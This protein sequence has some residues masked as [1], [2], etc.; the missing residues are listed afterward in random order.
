MSSTPT[1]THVPRFFTMHDV[2]AILIGLGILLAMVGGL[3]LL[4]DIPPRQY[5]AIIAWL[6][7]ALLVHDLLIAGLVFAV[8]VAGRRVAGAAIPAAP[9]V[10]VQ[11][12]LAVGA[13]VALIVVPEIVKDAAGTANPSILPLDYAANLAIFLAA[14]TV[15]T[16]AAVVLHGRLDRRRRESRLSGT[17]G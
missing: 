16:V 6:V 4:N 2:R 12:A 3:V 10:I 1:T 9:I 11:C 15:A 5:P 14:L 7:I 8:A 17:R 13:I